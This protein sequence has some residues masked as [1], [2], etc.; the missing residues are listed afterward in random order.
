MN[1]Y[2]SASQRKLR[3]KTRRGELAVEDLFG[4]SIPS[5]DLVGRTVKV[6]IRDG[7][8]SMIPQKAKD[9]S[10]IEND[11]KILI[12]AD[13][14]ADKQAT[15]IVSIIKKTDSNDETQEVL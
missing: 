8:E 12:L 3:F 7:L 4:L 13:I 15:E 5:L 2:K 6:D 14:I 10:I 9:K 11:L 1:I